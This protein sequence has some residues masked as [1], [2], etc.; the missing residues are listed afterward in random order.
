MPCYTF[1]PTVT[2]PT[3]HPALYPYTSFST[4]PG[5]YAMMSSPMRTKAAH[6]TGRTGGRL[7]RSPGSGDALLRQWGRVAYR[8]LQRPFQLDDEAIAHLKIALFDISAMA[9]SSTS[10]PRWRMKMMPSGLYGPD[11][12]CSTPWGN[13]ICADARIGDAV[14][15]APGGPTGLVVGDVGG[16]T[17]QEQR[18][19]GEAPK[20]VHAYRE[21][22]RLCSTVPGVS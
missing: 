21:R 7:C 10:A 19:L 4:L 11:W 15:R 8:T 22:R 1:R 18:A 5:T 13:A 3:S 6:Q 12:G 9:C 16:R 14:G 17:R 20:D 2:H